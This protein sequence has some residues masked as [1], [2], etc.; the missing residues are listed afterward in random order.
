[1]KSEKKL[2][3]LILMGITRELQ[4]LERLV[5][6]T[7]VKYN[8]EENENYMNLDHLISE[9]RIIQKEKYDLEQYEDEIHSQLNNQV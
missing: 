7:V 8:D 2:K 9:L 5:E 4:R 1:M 6:S 3:E